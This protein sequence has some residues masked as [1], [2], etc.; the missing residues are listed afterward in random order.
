MGRRRKIQV[1][2][3]TAANW[4]AANPVLADGEPGY[5]LSNR[6]LRVGDGLST[7]SDLTAVSM[8]NRPTRVWGSDGVTDLT[9]IPI[10]SANPITGGP[11]TMSVVNGRLR[12][13]SAASNT[14]SNWRQIVAL[15]G[16][17]TDS[18]MHSVIYPPSAMNPAVC[19]PQM[20]HAHRVR[21]NGNGTWSAFIFDTNI[22]G[23]TY[24]TIWNAVWQFS[25][26]PPTAGLVI[27]A[28]AQA[29]AM[30]DRTA[31]IS[32]VQRNAGT[33]ALDIIS[34]TKQ[35]IPFAVGDQL[36]VTPAVD[37][38]YAQASAPVV[39]ATADLIAVQNAG[40]ST[41]KAKAL[42]GGTVQYKAPAANS[43]DPRRN[44]PMHLVSR[45]VG[46]VGMVKT[47][48]AGDPVPG[49]QSVVDFGATGDVTVP[50]G[51]GANGY[52]VNHLYGAGNYVEYG[53]T[54]VVIL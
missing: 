26:N 52:V 4:S 15:P 1:R 31:Y 39:L 10:N 14:D 19:T 45:V 38:T 29:V 53:D 42:D 20:G 23:F 8:G 44:Y 37:A 22:F 18:E 40:E 11:F 3:D 43:A 21:D 50:T 13:A 41:L 34:F 9:V 27:A 24:N 51:L 2:R 12:V 36:V 28:A 25:P 32:S 46:K 47:W 35:G 17:A 5:D 49:W 48:L 30:T 7:W 33:P 54:D 6:S 16:S